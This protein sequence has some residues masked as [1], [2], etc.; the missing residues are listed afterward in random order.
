MKLHFS[1]FLKVLVKL[2]LSFDSLIFH[3]LFTL[4]QTLFVIQVYAG[5][6]CLMKNH[7]YDAEH[8]NCNISTVDNYTREFQLPRWESVPGDCF[9]P[10]QEGKCKGTLRGS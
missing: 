10:F 6:Q 2:N 1:E 5:P 4:L 3:S 9:V 8:C 7:C